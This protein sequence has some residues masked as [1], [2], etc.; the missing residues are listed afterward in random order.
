MKCCHQITLSSRNLLLLNTA[1]AGYRHSPTQPLHTHQ[2]AP[3]PTAILA[4]VGLTRLLYF[5]F[6]LSWDQILF[7]KMWFPLELPHTTHKQINTF[8]PKA[9]HLWVH[10]SLQNCRMLDTNSS[11]F[12]KKKGILKRMV[13][14]RRHKNYTARQN[15]RRPHLILSFSSPITLLSRSFGSRSF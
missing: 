2:L 8:F 6:S 9:S 5:L 3:V 12:C 13:Y 15:R 7:W 1:L 4:S 10:L 11:R 14:L